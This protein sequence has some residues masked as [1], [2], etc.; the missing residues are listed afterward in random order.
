MKPFSI[1]LITVLAFGILYAVMEFN[2]RLL[3]IILFFG[4]FGG[5]LLYVYK[6]LGDP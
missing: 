3:I 2:P 5:L 1:I 4:G 6:K